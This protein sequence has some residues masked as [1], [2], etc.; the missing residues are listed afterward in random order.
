MISKPDL[1]NKLTSCISIFINYLILSYFS[2]SLMEYNTDAI[3][4][5]L[6]MNEY[7]FVLLYYFSSIL[8]TGISYEIS[9]CIVY[10]RLPMKHNIYRAL[11][12]IDYII[13]YRS[14][15]SNLF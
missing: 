12:K 14:P 5:T 11:Y 15:N 2:H 6:N 13:S 8:I 9:S 7:N 10:R 3:K 1:L 4:N